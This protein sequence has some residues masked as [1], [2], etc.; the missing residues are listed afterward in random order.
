MVVFHMCTL[1][2]NG[3][4]QRREVKLGLESDPEPVL[5]KIQ[6]GWNPA[7]INQWVGARHV[8]M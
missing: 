3:H 8:S 4:N 5:I 7:Q 2:V 6:H 1:H